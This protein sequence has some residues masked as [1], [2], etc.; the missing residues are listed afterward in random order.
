MVITYFSITSIYY[1]FPYVQQFDIDLVNN[2]S[3]DYTALVTCLCLSIA[4]TGIHIKG[5]IDIV[6]IY[7]YIVN[8]YHA[9]RCSYILYLNNI[10]ELQLYFYL[11]TIVLLRF[12]CV[13]HFDSLIS[14]LGAS[15]VCVNNLKSTADSLT[16]PL[17]LHTLGTKMTLVFT[18]PLNPF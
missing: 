3:I 12:L 11:L 10:G 16:R 18:V 2:C 14:S 8:V 17:T 1:D 5:Y 13:C 7:S 4:P 6:L 15:I 9:V